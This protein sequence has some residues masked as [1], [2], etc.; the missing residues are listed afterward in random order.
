MLSR[1]K[2]S[3]GVVSSVVLSSWKSMYLNVCPLYK[4]ITTKF[5]FIAARTFTKF[6]FVRTFYFVAAATRENNIVRNRKLIC[7][8]ATF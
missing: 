3:L 4:I 8:L 7:Y 1:C 5:G 6:Q 2:S